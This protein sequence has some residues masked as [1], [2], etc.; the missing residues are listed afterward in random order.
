MLRT[1]LQDEG[2]EILAM[3]RAYLSANEQQ[4]VRE[5]RAQKGEVQGARTEGKDTLIKTIQT[6]MVKEIT[7]LGR[8]GPV[9]EATKSILKRS[10][11]P[12]TRQKTV[13]FG[14]NQEVEFT[15]GQTA[16]KLGDVIDQVKQHVKRGGTV[17]RKHTY[18]PARD[19]DFR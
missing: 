4:M 6:E 16:T 5:R 1:F 18:K 14:E 8:V 13:R 15:A 11:T 3:R 10:K 9:K 12:A 17:I 19:R 7:R 2:F